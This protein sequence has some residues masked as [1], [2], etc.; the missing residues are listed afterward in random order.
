MMWGFLYKYIHMYCHTLPMALCG[1]LHF[2][3]MDEK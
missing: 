1:R 2:R 3:F